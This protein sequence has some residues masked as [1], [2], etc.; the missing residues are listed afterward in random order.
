MTLK[1]T[2]YYR[3][4]S[5][6]VDARKQIGSESSW[7]LISGE[8]FTPMRYRYSTKKYVSTWPFMASLS[9]C[10]WQPSWKRHQTDCGGSFQ[11]WV[12]GSRPR[13]QMDQWW[14]NP[15]STDGAC[16]DPQRPCFLVQP[17]MEMREVL[18]RNK[19]TWKCLVYFYMMIGPWADFCFYEDV[20]WNWF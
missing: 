16:W 6:C 12:Q 1:V 4:I 10:S 17:W 3:S 2:C 7:C 18:K 14:V 13:S 9:L 19:N 11:T 20:I 5:N 15:Q 8:K